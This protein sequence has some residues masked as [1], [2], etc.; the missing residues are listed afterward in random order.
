[1]PNRCN[2]S[3]V[4]VAG[5]RA[6]APGNVAENATARDAFAAVAA[7]RVVARHAAAES[8][9]DTATDA[10]PT[11]AFHTADGQPHC[12]DARIAGEC[13]RHAAAHTAAAGV[14]AQSVA[15]APASAAVE[16]A[17][18]DCV[19]DLDV[20]AQRAAVPNVAAGLAVDAAVARVALVPDAAAPAVAV[21]PVVAVGVVEPAD[22][23]ELD[24]PDD[25]AASYA[26]ALDAAAVALE[27]VVPV[28][29]APPAFVVALAL[30]L[31]GAPGV[32]PAPEPAR[33]I[34]PMPLH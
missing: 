23:A 25:P 22:S 27:V 11:A 17:T 12:A 10:V 2:A 16:P 15:A 34:P 5:P 14:A 24:G 7:V 30:Y 20:A 28:H 6:R 32:A 13:R 31:A 26:L 3:S 8:A 29:P 9:D 18:V 1:M 19:P 4:N 21:L 33:L